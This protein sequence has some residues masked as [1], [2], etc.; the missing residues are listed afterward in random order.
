MSEPTVRVSGIVLASLMFQHFNSDSDVEGLVLGESRLDEQVTISDSQSD[1]IHIEEV[2]NV[3]KYVACGSLNSLYSSCGQINTEKLQEILAQHK[4]GGVQRVLGW[5]RQRRNSEQLVS[6]RERLVH[7]QLKEALSSPQLLF[8]LL[9]PSRLP[10]GATHRT[11]YSAFISRTRRLVKVPLLVHNLGL[12]EQQAYWK[13]SAPCCAAGYSLAMRRH[14]AQFFVSGGQLREVG[15]MDKMNE[16]LQAELQAACSEVEVSER[17][18]EELQEELSALRRRLGGAPP[19][20]GAP[21]PRGGG[22]PPTEEKPK[23]TGGHPG[24]AG[25]QFGGR[26]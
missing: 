23:A 15:E 26:G 3:Q 10:P 1:H 4:Q 21:P 8:M 6:F 18:L 9:T 16:A 25:S 5:Y 17:R 14:G 7:F 2:Y 12:L 11:E 20:P 24:S 19:P 22:P 13:V